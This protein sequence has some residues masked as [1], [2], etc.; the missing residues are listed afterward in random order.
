MKTLHLY[1][2]RQVL[3]TLVMT[4]GVFTF[5]M[6]LV[7]ILKEVLGLLVNRQVDFFT[8]VQAVGLLVPYVLPFALPMGMLTATLLVFGR[9]SAD[10][11]LTAVRASGVSLVSLVTPVLLLSVALS[12][13]SALINLQLAPQCRLAYKKLILSVGVAQ[14]AGSIP[15]RTYIKD[16][17][18]NCIVYISRVRETNLEDVLVLKLRDNR[19][20]SYSRAERGVISFNPSNRVFTVILSNA[21]QVFF[22]EDGR[23]PQPFLTETAEFSFTNAA[24][25]TDRR[26]VDLSD[27]TFSQLR[28]ELHA[29]EE[30]M[31]ASSAVEKLST[32]ELR[33][34]LRQMKSQRKLDLTLPVRVQMHRQVSFSFACIGFT[35]LGIPLG[36][37]AH[38]RETTF[39]IAA[40]LMLVV[41]YY[42]FFLLGLSLE[43]RP[44]LAPHLILWWPNF[45]FQAVGMVLLWRANRGV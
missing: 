35:L 20:E 38:R 28:E 16:F 45:L 23:L 26:R 17:N 8:V 42:S 6:M 30:R 39:G 5:V 32:D 31:A 10:H 36:I 25:R 15:E 2:T 24:P 1:L 29:L 7:S 22:R 19:Y 9:F 12:G 11:E 14:A 3:V 4:V 44:E 27:L 33:E 40:A 43:T 41:L 21:H 18:T 37:R 34:K 13:V